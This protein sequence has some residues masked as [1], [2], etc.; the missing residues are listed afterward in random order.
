MSTYRTKKVTLPFTFWLRKEMITSRA[1]KLCCLI[2]SCV[3]FYAVASWFL[4]WETRMETR[5]YIARLA[6]GILHW[7]DC[8]CSMVGLMLTFEITSHRRLSS[9]AC[10]LNQDI[11]SADCLQV[12]WILPYHLSAG[13]LS[14]SDRPHCC[15]GHFGLGECHAICVD[16]INRVENSCRVSARVSGWDK[17]PYIFTPLLMMLFW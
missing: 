4:I 11:V 3:C 7:R 8:C 10:L 16:R 17:A 2:V 15:D 9:A 12:I 14:S 5:H 13:S 6:V 1:M